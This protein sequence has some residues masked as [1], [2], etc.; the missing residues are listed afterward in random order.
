MVR[1]PITNV[2]ST[3]SGSLN[4]ARSLSK[5]APEMQLEPRVTNSAYSIARRSRWICGAR[6]PLAIPYASHPRDA[7]E[8]RQ[9]RSRKD[10]F[11]PLDKLQLGIDNSLF[12]S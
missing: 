11:R 7:F 3:I 4:A 5:N 10:L 1:M 9:L 2:S 6:G 8:A 12:T